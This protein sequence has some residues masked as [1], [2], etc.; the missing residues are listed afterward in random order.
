MYALASGNTLPL[1][2]SCY[3]TSS[4]LPRKNDIFRLAVKEMW[5]SPQ[6]IGSCV[7]TM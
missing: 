6:S 2:P 3:P 7:V 1:K 5:G 4:R